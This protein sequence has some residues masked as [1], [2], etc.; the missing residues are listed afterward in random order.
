ME[1][2]IDIFALQSAARRTIA[3]HRLGISARARPTQSRRHNNVIE[4][5]KSWTGMPSLLAKVPRSPQEL[6]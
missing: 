3:Q 6:R 2:V 1:P 4:S 5:I